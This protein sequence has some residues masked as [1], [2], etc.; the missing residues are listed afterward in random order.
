MAALIKELE[1]VVELAMDITAD[2]RGCAH[3]L[4]VTLLNEDL[5]D[6]LAKKSEVSLR[7]NLA[8]FE[9]GK[10]P[11]TVRFAAHLLF[12]LN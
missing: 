12:D 3:R 5:L 9:G 11:V 2:G 7:E 8:L 10:P 1:K 6:F 4:D